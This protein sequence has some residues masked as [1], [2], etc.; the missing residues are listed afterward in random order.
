MIIIILAMFACLV[1]LVARHY[2]MKY[3]TTPRTKLLSKVLRSFRHPNCCSPTLS[4]VIPCYNEE[5]RLPSMLAD[6]AAYV[7]ALEGRP[8]ANRAFRD[9]EFIV[10]DDCSRDRTVQ[11]ATSFF[12]GQNAA[13]SKAGKDPILYSIESVRPNHGK[14]FA[15]RTGFLAASGDLVLMADGDNATKFADVEKLAARLHQDSS[16]DVVV[17]SRA[18]LEDDSI[19]SR[20]LFRTILMK[21][22]HVVVH[23]TYSVVTW[24][25]CQI[26]DTQCGFKLFRR[27]PSEDVFLNSRLER[28]AFDVEVLMLLSIFGMRVA[29][30]PVTWQEIPGSKVNFK[31]M[32][33]M[34]LEC[35]LMCFAYPSG[36]WRLKKRKQ[37]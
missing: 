8:E 29:E 21:V 15:V 18:H 19:A 32:A 20:T 26:R 5:Q 34:G 35:L 13:R 28:W 14:G 33:Q 4:V 11:V 17:G 3:T 22:F 9:V 30:V 24:R 23:V 16:L 36:M 31:G 7:S 37:S 12:D 25:R 10:V 27:A 1:S 2:A 6:C